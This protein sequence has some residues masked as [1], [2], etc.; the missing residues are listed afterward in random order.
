MDAYIA[1][2]DLPV[3]SVEGFAESAGVHRGTVIAWRTDPGRFG[4]DT[5][6]P[7]PDPCD[8]SF[9]TPIERLYNH[10]AVYDSEKAAA[11]KNAAV[12]TGILNT[13]CGWGEPHAGREVG[14]SARSGRSAAGGE[15]RV[16]LT[17]ED[18]LDAR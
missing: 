18:R 4:N 11:A 3:K 7:V 10:L 12:Y 1:R 16:I 17:E 13:A 6:S 5:Y 9:R 2:S 14:A 8:V 15:I